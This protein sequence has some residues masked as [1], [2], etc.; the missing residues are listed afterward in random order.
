MNIL[1]ERGGPAF[2]NSGKWIV[3]SDIHAHSSS[4]HR[5]RDGF[6]VSES[7]PCDDCL[8]RDCH[9]DWQGH[10]QILNVGAKLPN[11]AF[12]GGMS[13]ASLLATTSLGHVIGIGA[14]LGLATRGV[15]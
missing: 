11:D 3:A 7:G 4:G 8:Q 10:D 6:L 13:H 5:A 1:Y 15:L 14:I 12:F 9:R 2:T